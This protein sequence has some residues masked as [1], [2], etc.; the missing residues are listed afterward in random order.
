MK[1]IV[2]LVLSL[3]A[4]GAWGNGYNF[5]RTI[6]ID[7]TKVPNTDQ[8]N[9]PVLISGTYTFLKTTG[10]GG[11]VQNANGFDVIFTSD[12]AGSTKLNWETVSYAGPT[13]VVEYWVKVGTVSHT[14]DTVFYLFYGNA[15]V[16]TD[17]SNRTA[18]WDAN[19][20]GVYHLPDGTT[21]TMNDST[22]NARNGSGSTSPAAIA[23]QVDGGADNGSSNRILCGANGNFDFG[24]NGSF[25]LSLWVKTTQ[26][27]TKV[28]VGNIGTSNYWLGISSGK[29]SMNAGNAATESSATVSDGSWHLLSG[30]H[31]G[32]GQ[33]TKVYVDG[34]ERASAPT[35]ANGD[36]G[37]QLA[38]GAFGTSA[39]FN[40][41]GQ[42][43]E[44]H[45]SNAVRSADWLRSEFNNQSNPATFYAVGSAATNGSSAAVRHRVVTQ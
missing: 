38:L 7:H 9:F 45:I 30:V 17:Q 33:L 13:G 4:F 20:Q 14:S 23:G 40:W 25:T 44:G 2:L 6:T 28:A 1:A 15:A 22:A 42:Y 11:D 43:D 39:G 3:P 26:T 12:S 24:N 21:L 35:T 19:T 32:P 37:S 34:V 31:D 36:T 41:V 27:G 10:A 8:T 29:A 16:S 18:S 5:R